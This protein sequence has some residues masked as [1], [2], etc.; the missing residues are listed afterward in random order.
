VAPRVM[1]IKVPSFASIAND[2]INIPNFGMLPTLKSLSRNSATKIKKIKEQF[3][4]EIFK[5]YEG[6]IFH[7]GHASHHTK[8][9]RKVM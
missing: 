1:L 2:E 4:K 9:C 8:F 6:L 5:L 3:F 7:Y